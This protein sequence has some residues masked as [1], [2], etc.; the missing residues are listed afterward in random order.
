M[1]IAG[2]MKDA[3]RNNPP[4]SDVIFF[5]SMNSKEVIE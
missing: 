2:V 4:D 3:R 1:H 5:E